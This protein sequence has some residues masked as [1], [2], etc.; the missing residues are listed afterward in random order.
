ME[1]PEAGLT[2]EERAHNR[3]MDTA[4]PSYQDLEQ[5][6]DFTAAAASKLG[7]GCTVVLA[8]HA[9]DTPTG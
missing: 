9:P 1:R 7:L 2:L 3:R 4:T 5:P 6:L 8:S